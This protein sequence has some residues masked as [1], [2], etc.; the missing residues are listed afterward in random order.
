MEIAWEIPAKPTPPG[1]FGGVLVKVVSS[2]AATGCS[3][4]PAFTG[5]DN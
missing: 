5:L 2:T 4:S 3:L 1:G